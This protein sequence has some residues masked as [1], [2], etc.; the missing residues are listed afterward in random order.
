M[1]KSDI[2]QKLLDAVDDSRRGFLKK[3]IL[4]SAFVVPAVS[5]FSMSGLG[6]DE[7]AGFAPNSTVGVPPP[8]HPLAIDQCKSPLSRPGDFSNCDFAGQNLSGQDL[9]SLVFDGANFANADLSNSNLSN[10]V[11]TGANFANAN[12]SGANLTGANLTGANL[13]G[14]D[15][16]GAVIQNANLN[17]ANLKDAVG[18]NEP[19]GD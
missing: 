9:N 17:R 19:G 18:I 11:L 10:C 5:S 14:A 3:L 13:S 12:L 7:A 2:S 4:G 8:I 6:V 1:G 15:M 16:T